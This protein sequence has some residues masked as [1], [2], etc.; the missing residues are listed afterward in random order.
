M[1]RLILKLCCF[2]SI[3]LIILSACCAPSPPPVSKAQ[4]D[5]AKT[6]ALN[7]EKQVSEQDAKIKALEGELKQKEAKLAELKAYEQQLKDEG[8]LGEE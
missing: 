4:I 8:F 3:T 1:C 7:V 6:A 5:E 2:L